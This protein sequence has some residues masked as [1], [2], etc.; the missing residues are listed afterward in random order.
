LITND[1]KFIFSKAESETSCMPWP[2][3]R[4]AMRR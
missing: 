2:W 3:A 1:Q 4:Q